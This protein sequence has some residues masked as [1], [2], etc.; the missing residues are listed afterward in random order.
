[1]PYICE[2]FHSQILIVCICISFFNKKKQIFFVVSQRNF[3]WSYV[4]LTFQKKEYKRMV[5]SNLFLCMDK[6]DMYVLAF[7]GIMWMF[8]LRERDNRILEEKRINYPLK[9]YYVLNYTILANSSLSKAIHSLR[10]L[11]A[12]VQLSVVGYVQSQKIWLLIFFIIVF[13]IP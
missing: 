1:M 8:C 6:I 13:T 9:L 2:I 12:F 3:E 5:I 7:K 11:S 10:V 4:G